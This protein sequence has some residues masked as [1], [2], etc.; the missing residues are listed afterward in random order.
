M[1]A[2]F[3]VQNAALVAENQKLKEENEKLKKT[4]F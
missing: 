1:L 2:E 4:S 3:S